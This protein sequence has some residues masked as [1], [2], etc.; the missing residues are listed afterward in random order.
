MQTARLLRVF[1][2]ISILL[3]GILIGIGIH[4]Y[5]NIPLMAQINL[6]DVATLVLTVFLAVYIPEVI[7]HKMQNTRD[8]KSL[9]ENRITEFLILL[10]GVNSTVQDDDRLDQREFL[11]I[12]NTL[13]VSKHKLE[14]ITSLL[15]YAKLGS[16]E[17]DIEQLNSLTREHSQLLLSQKLEKEGGV[18]YP[19]EVKDQ[20]E[21]LYN[22][23]D[24]ATSLLIFRISDS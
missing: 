10:K 3:I 7:D 14:T 4:H 15:G 19:E 5:K 9:L 6:I 2:Y 20:E 18:I 22:E 16:F 12:Q 23:I 17:N 11:D 13:D 8:K 1:I 24:K 21:H